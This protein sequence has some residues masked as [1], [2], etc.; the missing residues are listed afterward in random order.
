MFANAK[1]FNKEDLL[2]VA[3]DIGEVIPAKVTISYLKNLILNSDEYKKD[4]DFVT[5]VLIT[6]VE[7]R[8]QRLEE[9]ERQKQYETEEKEKQR[10][11]EM[12][13]NER[14]RQYELELARIQAR[15]V[16][17][18][19]IHKDGGTVP[20]KRFQY[21]IQAT[22]SGSRAREIVESLPPKSA[23]YAKAVESL[24]ARF[25]RNDLLVEVYVQELLKLVISVHKNEKSS[26]TSLYDKLESHMRALENLGVMTDKCASILYPIVESCFRRK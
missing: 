9:K 7:D 17:F 4:S 22:V 14:Q 21:L 10:Q 26:I 11:Y 16:E 13:E 18:E 1:S 15:V 23:N 24:K 5:S 3:G 12:E 2:L 20:E 8:K 25:G 6:T 19:H